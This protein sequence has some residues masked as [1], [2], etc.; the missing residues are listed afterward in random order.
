MIDYRIRLIHRL[1]VGIKT[2][3][4]DIKRVARNKMLIYRLLDIAAEA[5]VDKPNKSNYTAFY[6]AMV[7]APDPALYEYNEIYKKNHEMNVFLVYAN[8]Y[9]DKEVLPRARKDKIVMDTLNSLVMAKLPDKLRT[10]P[11]SSINFFDDGLKPEIFFRS[12][13]DIMQYELA[14]KNSKTYVKTIKLARNF[15]ARHISSTNSLIRQL[16]VRFGL[17]NLNI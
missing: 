17:Q 1:L 13:L 8:R 9:R 11:Q 6:L 16:L 14:T 2:V 12:L 10:G 5:A 15:G 4:E 7:E 3:P